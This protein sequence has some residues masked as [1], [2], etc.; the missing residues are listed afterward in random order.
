MRTRFF[1]AFGLAIVAA[2]ACATGSGDFEGAGGGSS[3]KSASVATGTGGAGGAGGLGGAGGAGGLGGAGGGGGMCD[4]SPCKLVD[5]QCGCAADEQCGLDPS[6]G[7]VTCVDAGDIPWKELCP[8]G[9][10]CEPG[11]IC[12]T[13][14][15]I[16]LCGKFC[17]DDSQ[18]GGPGGI[19]IRALNDGNGDPIPGAVLCTESCDPSTSMGCPGAGTSCQLGREDMGQMRF[20]TLCLASGAGMQGAA[21]MGNV[22]CAPSFGCFNDGVS[23]MCLKYCK[24]ASP[25][26]PAGTQC[27]AITIGMEQ[28]FIENEQYG[29][30]I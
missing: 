26:C 29:A 27:A 19:C 9:T 11:H 17:D 22:D 30:C 18:C 3:S 13:V 21:C 5:P 6:D 10:E 7:S 23:D 12:V 14:T 15:G 28:V 24:V 8:P 4:E 20:F 25:S 2:G 1:L 16:S